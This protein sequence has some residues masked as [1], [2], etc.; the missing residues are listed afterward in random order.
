MTPRSRSG[1]TEDNPAQPKPDS[2]K[3]DHDTEGGSAWDDKQPTNPPP[4]LESTSSARRDD[5]AY[6]LAR[7]CARFPRT[8][9]TDGAQRLTRLLRP[10][11]DQ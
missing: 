11:S 7:V 8:I 9:S 5:R 1:T 3:G 6:H 10:E 4:R 2:A